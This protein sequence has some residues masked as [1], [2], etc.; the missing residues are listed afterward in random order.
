MG[1]AVATR[2]SRY[3]G[4]C[5]TRRDFNDPLIGPNDLCDRHGPFSRCE[6]EAE[7]SINVSESFSDEW[8]HFGHFFVFTVC[9]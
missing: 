6:V 4:P 7:W 1:I 3:L 5:L 9:L 8:Y 2:I